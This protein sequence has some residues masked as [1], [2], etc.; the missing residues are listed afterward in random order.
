M[1]VMLKTL[2]EQSKAMIEMMK[3]QSDKNKI[4]GSFN[5]ANRPADIQQQSSKYKL[6]SLT[7]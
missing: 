1:A 7:H 3:I 6:P 2:T 4:S 5:F